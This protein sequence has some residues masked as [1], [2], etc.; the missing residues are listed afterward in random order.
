[1]AEH[2]SMVDKLSARHG[3]FNPAPSAAASSGGGSSGEHQNN[4]TSYF[5]SRPYNIGDACIHEC[6]RK[7][8]CRGE[9]A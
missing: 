8:R 5:S 6:I 9:L 1:M 3:I 4:E 2:D 7:W